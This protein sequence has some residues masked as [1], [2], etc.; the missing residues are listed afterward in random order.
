MTSDV[1]IEQNVCEVLETQ[2]THE[3]GHGF[4]LADAR[5][6]II[7]NNI[8]QAYGGVNTGGGG[9]SDLVIVNNFFANDLSFEIYPGG[10]GLEDCPNTIVQNNIFYDQ[11]YHTISVTGNTNGQKIDHNLAY[12]SDGRPSDCYRIDY[13]CVVPASVHDLWDVDPLFVD[14]AAGDFHLQGDSPAID[15]GNT[16]EEVPNDFDGN[17]RPLG[18]GHDIGAFEYVGASSTFIDVPVDHWAYDYIEVLYQEGYVAGCSTDPLMYCPDQIITRAESAVFITRGVHGAETLP[19]QP[20]EQIF[21]DVLLNEW[22]AKW[23]T[24]LWNDGYTDGCGTDPL[25][26][27]PLQEHTR[28]EGCV[29]FLRMMHGVDYIPPDPQG[30]F[31][32]VP[33]DWWG[34]KW[35]EAAYNAGLILACET[36]PEMEFCPNEAL[37]RAMGAFMMVQVKGLDVP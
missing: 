6:I 23:S 3:N 36:E 11:P 26:Y 27:C 14:P 8:I 9:N 7:R 10:V 33:L 18:G 21:A 1:I 12:R 15:A 35:I 32:D 22:F 4:M 17:S 29:F 5:N 20:T 37:D 28:T 24:A 34:A 13:S 30:I 31:V 2:V 16:L 19:I 25:I